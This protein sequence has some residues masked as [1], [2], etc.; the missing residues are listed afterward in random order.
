MLAELTATLEKAAA[1]RDGILGVLPGLVASGPGW[2]PARELTREPY[3]AL[4]GFV[5]EAAELYGAPR[6]VAAAVW[7]KTYGYW[8]TL[9]MALGWAVNRRVPLMRLE[10]TLVRPSDA[11]VTIAATEITVAV[12]PGD[13]I[14]GSPGTVVSDDL[15]ATIRA[16]LMDGHQPLI[17]ALTKLTRLGRRN[18]WGS[19][20]EAFVGPLM[21]DGPYQRAADLLRAIG[22]P[23]DGLIEPHEDGYR[24]RT[25]C[26]WVTLPDE[27]AC[28]TCCLQSGRSS[29]A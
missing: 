18:L 15:G 21:E 20:A 2:I 25:C 23:V 16:A 11:G 6:H 28:S 9:P 26:L 7:W 29:S 19:T 1:E 4:A 5:D 13:P 14:A 3:Q 24:R 8:H 27:E 22:R 10:H 17:E 12:E